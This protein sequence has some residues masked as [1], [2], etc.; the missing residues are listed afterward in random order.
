MR[1]HPTLFKL[2]VLPLSAFLVTFPLRAD[3]PD[4]K[5]ALDAILGEKKQSEE[6]RRE[7]A[8]NRMNEAWEAMIPMMRKMMQVILEVQLE[9]AR[10]PESARSIAKFKKNLYDALIKEGFSPDQA[11]QITIAT[12]SPSATYNSN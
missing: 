4:E 11:L 10:D 3:K 2:L 12:S 8:K 1:F 7:E 5:D 6:Q 9:V